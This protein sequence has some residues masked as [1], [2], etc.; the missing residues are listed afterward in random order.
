MSSEE[1]NTNGKSVKLIVRSK[2]PAPEPAKLPAPL[3]IAKIPSPSS[4]EVAP[5]APE[6]VVKSLKLQIPGPGS[7]R[8]LSN[9]SFVTKWYLLGPFSISA[10]LDVPSSELLHREIID[11]EKDLSTATSDAGGVKWRKFAASKNASM[12]CVDASSVIAGKEVPSAIYLYTEISSPQDLPEL[13]M[14]T[15]SACYIKI[16]INGN[17]I[18][19]YNREP[20]KDDMDQDTIKGI[21][22][23]KGRNSI[24]MKC[25]N[26]SGDWS[27]YI[28]LSSS[29]DIPLAFENN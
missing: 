12:G 1:K 26:I 14:H 9:E 18:H 5:Q 20:R 11:H 2:E 19:A 29:G 25:V 23:K 27:F 22:M 10:G 7:S 15:G 3:E 4:V 17:L 24:L 8:F 13:I 28:R 16:W 21:T 6:T